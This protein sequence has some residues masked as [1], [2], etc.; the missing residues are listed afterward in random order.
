MFYTQQ[1]VL[2]KPYKIN[3]PIVVFTSPE[4]NYGKMTSEPWP[5]E[6]KH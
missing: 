3:H 1:I 4:R 6:Q 5:A 2:Y